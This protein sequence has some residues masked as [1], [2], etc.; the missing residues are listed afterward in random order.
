M[1][2]EKALFSVSQYT[3]YPQSFEDDVKLYAALGIEG[4]EIVE[5]KLSTDRGRAREQLAMVRDAGLK[6]TSVQPYVHSPFPHNATV[7][8]DPKDPAGRLARFRQTVDLFAECCPGENIALV[9]GGGIAPDYNF[10]L[11]HRTARE[12][13]PAL[14]E[15]AGERGIR[16][17]FEH[18]H[19]ILMN[20]YTFISTLD[21]AVTLVEDVGHPAFGLF[22]DAWH[23]WHEPGVCERL[24]PLG[25]DAFGMHI[26]DWPAEQPRDLSDRLLPGD[27]VVDLAAILGA[28]R[29]SGYCGAY[30]LELFSAEHLPDSLWNADPADVIRQGRDGFYSAWNAGARQGGHGS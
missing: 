30:C 16:I 11:A 13:F 4:I 18:L 8:A 26:G 3:T 20:A 2:A 28:L 15:Y 12:F 22:L 9:A 5:E 1:S 10:Q 14:A 19:P 7:E 21:E 27:G 17:G 24:E 25:A 29:R 23:I 6:V